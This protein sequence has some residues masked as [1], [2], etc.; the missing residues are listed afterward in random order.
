MFAVGSDMC[1]PAHRAQLAVASGVPVVV[2]GGV[3]RK[4]CGSSC[5]VGG[6]R[7][8]ADLCLGRC[9]AFWVCWVGGAGSMSAMRGCQWRGTVGAAECGLLVGRAGLKEAPE[10]RVRP[11]D[12]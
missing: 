9:L 4:A 5:L 12:G 3:G 11:V 1:R 7:P 6:L 2:G 10:G 8:G